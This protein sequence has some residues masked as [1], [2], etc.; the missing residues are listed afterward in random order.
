MIAWSAVRSGS[1]DPAA[2]HGAGRLGV[3]GSWQPVWEHVLPHLAQVVG[4]AAFI[5]VARRKLVLTV[6][7]KAESR[8]LRELASNLGTAFDSAPVAV[9]LVCVDEAAGGTSGRIVTA[10]PAMC[11]LVGR[12]ADDLCGRGYRHV[13]VHPDDQEHS[14]QALRDLLDEPD[15]QT[16]HELRYVH[17]DGSEIWVQVTASRTHDSA[18]RGTVSCRSGTSPA[19]GGATRSCGTRPTTTRSPGCS[20]ATGS[21]RSWTASSPACGGSTLRRRCSS[22]T[23]TASSTSTTPTATPP[24]TSCW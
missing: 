16:V 11:R 9:A 19:I 20:T 17:R 15:A 5:A 24:V 1:V 22:W 12:D 6:M 8:S 2:M 13:L 23:S 3:P 21:A 18:G 14:A 4:G 10:N 7:T